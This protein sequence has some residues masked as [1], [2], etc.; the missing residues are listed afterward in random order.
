MLARFRYWNRQGRQ[1]GGSDCQRAARPHHQGVD[2][3]GRRA[4]AGG[5]GRVPHRRVRQDERPGGERWLG[6][7]RQDAV[8]AVRKTALTYLQQTPLRCQTSRIVA[9][10]RPPA[11]SR[12]FCLKARFADMVFRFPYTPPSLSPHTPRA[13]PF[14]LYAIAHDLHCAIVLRGRSLNAIHHPPLV[15][16]LPNP[17]PSPRTACP[18]TRPWSSSPSPFPRR[19]S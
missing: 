10:V 4:G 14:I 3:G 12:T 17:S 19:A 1:R 9:A 13:H 16:L 11:R 5:Q 6:A 15:S 7:E 18:S 8:G 2:T